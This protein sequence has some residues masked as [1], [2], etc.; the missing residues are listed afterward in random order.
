MRLL[1]KGGRVVDPISKTEKNL[2]ILIEHGKITELG[3]DLS[4]TL[5]N[6]QLTEIDVKGKVVAPG[7]IDMH[8][9]LR[10]P[11][12][13]DEETIETG[14][15]AAAAGGFTS[16]CSMPNTDPTNDNSSIT[17]FILSQARE[18]G[19]I[20]VFPI[21]SLTL[22]SKGENLAEF[23]YQKKA[24]IVAV[25][26]DG[27]PVMDAELMRRAMEYA[28]MFNLPVITHS[29]DLNLSSAGQMNEGYYST[30]LG[31]KGVPNAAEEVMIARDIILCELTGVHLHVAHVSTAGSVRLIADAKKRGVPITSEVTPHH[32]SLSDESIQTFDTN[33][34]V[35]PPLRTPKD[36]EALK[37]GLKE[38]II[39]VIATDHA[40]HSLAEKEL[41]FNYASCGMIG[42]ETALPLALRLYHSK[43]MEL[44]DL[45][46]KFTINPARILDLK[47][48]GCLK[49]QMDAD[50]TIID[51]DKKFIV[52]VNK[53]KSKSKN[54]PFNG[55]ELKGKA[56]CTIVK[57]RIVYSELG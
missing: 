15:K 26:D 19:K 2:D 21:G 12:R 5:I 53:F 37:E 34:K 33:Y 40:P 4:S 54:S 42:L 41:E 13:E 24:G 1:I 25:S 8:T 6:K 31:F 49:T 45:I 28:K 48:K 46:A 43:I 9:H 39:D 23:G 36:I 47:N 50:L 14:T 16:I 17:E 27:R 57:G 44:S 35:N 18:V 55:W 11:G 29:E 22:K 30:I 32:L 20:N 52:D 3:E 51:L 38:G 10:E 56:V 7:L